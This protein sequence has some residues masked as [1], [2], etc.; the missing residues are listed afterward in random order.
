MRKIIIDIDNTLWDLAPILYERL[1]KTSPGFPH[2]SQWHSWTFWKGLISAERL[3]H[4]I[5]D[6]HL[7][8]DR[9]EPYSEAR[10]FLERL[11]RNGFYI[12]IA[13]HREK[14]TLASTRRWLEKNNLSYDEIHLSYDKSVLF[15]ESWAIVDDS[16]VTLEK[17]KH[18]GIVRSG[19]KNP[20][21]AHED[22]PLFGT[23]TEIYD[24]LSAEC[25]SE[26]KL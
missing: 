9:Y 21:N 11:K 23:L 16:P 12:V 22:H 8:Q 5:R 10:L 20:W 13:S 1:S 24:Y 26:K 25:K 7:E 15:D 2:H 18:A 14:E 6:V 4:I 3:Y 19:L 17:A